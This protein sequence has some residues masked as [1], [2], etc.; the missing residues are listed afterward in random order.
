[1]EIELKLAVHPRHAARIRRHPLLCGTPPQRRLLLSVYFDTPGFDLMRRSIALRLRRV[2]DQWIQTLKAETQSVGALTCRPEWEAV[3]ADGDHPDFSLLSLEA[4]DLLAGIPLKQI[5]PVFI[6]EFQRIT[7]QIGDSRAQ[8]E[9]AFDS[10]KIAAGESSLAIS[11]VEIELKSGTP[12]F[13]FDAA[14]QLLEQVPLQVEPRSK[15]QRGYAL[16]GAIKSAPVKAVYP[17][18]AQNQAAGEAWQIFMQAA[19]VQLIANVPGFLEQ[20]HDS[21]YL[22]QL[23]VAMR[24]LLAGAALAKSLR[25]SVPQW[26]QSLRELMGALNAARDWDVFLQQ[27]L[28]AVLPSSDT[29]SHNHAIN[30]ATLDLMRDA[31]LRARRQAQALLRESEFTRLILD[32]GSSFLTPPI[33][34]QQR[35]AKV[36][37]EA[38]FDQCW[39]KLCKR[40]HNFTKLNP[41][42]RHRARIAA[43]KMRYAVDAFAPI[44]GK[45]VDSFMATLSVLQ[46]ELGYANDLI[47]GQQ[48]LHQLP[49]RSAEFGFALGRICG[50]LEGRAG[51]QNSLF[52]DSWKPVAQSKLFWRA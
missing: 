25:Q 12:E 22:H 37:S 20:A 28:P 49:K 48:L 35:D 11:E 6:T 29:T 33:D 26:Y 43:K 7:W 15:A 41:R 51:E 8:V 19:L 50:V 40:C 2:N 23:R 31:A 47:A 42:Q 17:V 27:T 14:A 52:R 46:G 36:W 16:C 1:M 44:Y 34:M 45:Q 30:D 21:E 39:Q 32:I 4:L 9:V 13:L 3:V 18:I 5:A 38:V 10:G 24:S